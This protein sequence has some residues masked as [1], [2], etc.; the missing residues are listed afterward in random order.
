MHHPDAAAQLLEDAGLGGVSPAA[1]RRWLPA[2][3]R[4]IVLIARGFWL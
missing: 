4:R 2:W 3:L 1:D